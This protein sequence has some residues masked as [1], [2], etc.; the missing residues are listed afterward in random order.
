MLYCKFCIFPSE[1]TWHFDKFSLPVETLLKKPG[2]EHFFFL[3]WKMSLSWDVIS[4]SVY[5]CRAY[6][7]LSTNF[8]YY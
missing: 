1:G 3:N 6:I 5:G 7:G 8:N 4:Y 2:E